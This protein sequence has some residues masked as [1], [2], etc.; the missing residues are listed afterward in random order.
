MP[1]MALASVGVSLSGGALRWS[2][3]RGFAN[4]EPGAPKACRDSRPR[5]RGREGNRPATAPG[6]AELGF[7]TLPQR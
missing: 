7:M 3:A 2:I 6:I 4:T 5:E 1:L